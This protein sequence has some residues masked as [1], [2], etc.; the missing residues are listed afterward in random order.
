MLCLISDSQHTRNTEIRETKNGHIS[1]RTEQKQHKM[2]LDYRKSCDPC[3]LKTCKP[4]TTTDISTQ[5]NRCF[6]VLYIGVFLLV[7][8]TLHIEV[9]CIFKV[10]KSFVSC[11]SLFLYTNNDTTL[12]NILHVGVVCIFKVSASFCFC[13]LCM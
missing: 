2:H 3:M 7:L 11:I 8:H 10:N 4:N 12:K 1:P 9:V 13:I 5:P 6:F